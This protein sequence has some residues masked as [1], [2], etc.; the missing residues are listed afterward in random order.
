MV[1]KLYVK[2]FKTKW[3]QPFPMQAPFYR[4]KSAGSTAPHRRKVPMWHR[5]MR[6]TQHEPWDTATTTGEQVLAKAALGKWLFKI[7]Y[8]FTELYI[9]FKCA[10]QWYLVNLQ[11]HSTITII[12][13]WNTFIHLI[14]FFNPIYSWSYSTSWT[15]HWST[16]C[17]FRFAFSGNFI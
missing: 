2:Y 13:L 14:R 17:S 11:C 15:N 1:Y 6:E 10:S 4:R 8:S 9:K 12:Q 5:P 3:I 16:F 7:F